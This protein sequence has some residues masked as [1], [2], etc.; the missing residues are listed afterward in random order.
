MIVYQATNQKNGKVYIG[1]TINSLEKRIRDHK[2]SINTRH[3][4]LFVNALRKYGINEFDWDV[5]CECDSIDSLNKQEKYYISIFDSAN[6]VVG[7]NLTDG[8]LNHSVSE[9]TRDKIRRALTGVKHTKERRANI[10]KALKGRKIS[11]E[12]CKRMGEARIGRVVSQETKEKISKANSGKTMSQLNK[13]RVRIRSINQW[14]DPQI[15]DRILKS[16]A[17]FF[18]LK[19]S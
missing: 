8:G 16:R 10:S 19:N 2:S 13:D 14:K 17:E 15:R 9:R 3:T 11:P 12:V 18:R 5:L 1:Q 6:R 4:N 7:Y